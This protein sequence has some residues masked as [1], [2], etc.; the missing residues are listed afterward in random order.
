MDSLLLLLTIFFQ[1]FLV[2]V[3]LGKQF[4]CC[5]FVVLLVLVVVPSLCFAGGC[6]GAAFHYFGSTNKWNLVS[7]IVFDSS[8]DARKLSLGFIL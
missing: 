4:R 7:G 3:A 1:L 6:F 2:L 8:T 5:P